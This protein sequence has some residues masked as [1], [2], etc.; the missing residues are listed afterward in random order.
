MH[1]MTGYG[2][3]R[4]ESS[5]RQLTVQIR[6]VNHRFFDLKLRLPPP[7][8]D[9][10]LEQRVNQRVRGALERGALTLTLHDS[11]QAI[12][13][14]NV[15]LGLA[16]AYHR[17]L[18]QLRAQLELVEPVSLTLVASQ[19]G[20][21]SSGESPA[22]SEQLWSELDP[23]LEQALA[24]LREARHRE[25]TAL[26][27]D[28]LQ[29]LGLLRGFVV[30]LRTLAAQAPVEVQRRLTERL[31]KLLEVPIDPQR[32]AQEVALLADRAD[33]TEELV[34]L[35]VHFDEIARLC[36]LGEPVGR[37]LDFLAQEL[38]REFNTIGSKSQRAEVAQRVVAAKAEVE[39]LREQV[40]NVE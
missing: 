12:G 28:L 21:L 3:G 8:N 38:H 33:V 30:E 31:E 17:A 27:T 7:W 25:G 34:R 5:G 14:V 29:R 9:A 19:P 16:S 13:A 40:Q 32:L 2:Q 26:R 22:D 39:R 4:A 36:D 23:A 1:S 35:G 15:N 37:R 10:Q 18:E 24:A 20:V 6:S 11:S